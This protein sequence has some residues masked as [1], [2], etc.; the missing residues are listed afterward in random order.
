MTDPPT[1]TRIRELE[2]MAISALE[3]LQTVEGPERDAVLLRASLAVGEL[4]SIAEGATAAPTNEG[5]SAERWI[6]LAARLTLEL[7][8]A[9]SD[10]VFYDVDSRPWGPIR[11]PRRPRAWARRTSDLLVHRSIAA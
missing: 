10:T 1:E 8:K 5:V 7:V 2:E 6:Q 4:R 3:R 11:P 9:W